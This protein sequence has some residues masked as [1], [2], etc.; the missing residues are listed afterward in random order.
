MRKN[1]HLLLLLGLLLISRAGSSQ[2]G[3]QLS[4]QEALQLAGENN[5]TAKSAEAREL[6]ARGQYRM[7]NSVF[8]PGLT[9]S[10]TGITTND[11]LSS[12]GFKLKQEVV[13]QADF[14]PAKLNDSY[15][16]V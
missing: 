3:M 9:V 1:Y 14:D 11:P 7:A 13:T 6:A 12:F 15:N 5:L 8:L 2:P 10:T 16:F 4:L